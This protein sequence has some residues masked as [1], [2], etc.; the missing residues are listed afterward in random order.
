MGTAY[1]ISPE[2]IDSG[3]TVD[4]RSDLYSLAAI[5]FEML[6][7]Q[8]PYRGSNVMELI[9]KHKSTPIPALQPLRPDLPPIVDQFFQ[10]GLAKYPEQRYQTPQ[11]FIEALQDLRRAA[12][13]H[14]QPTSLSRASS[15]ALALPEQSTVI[16]VPAS[17]EKAPAPRVAARLVHLATGKIFLLSNQEMIIGRRDPLRN[18]YPDISLADKMVGRR[19]ACIRN[20]QGTFTIEDLHSRNRTRLNG[21]FLLPGEERALKH[22]DILRFGNIEMRFELINGQQAPTETKDGEEATS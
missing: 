8:P 19:H 10:K 20:R 12:A 2:Q 17:T 7:G 15:S 22:G 18:L 16:E 1:Y 3:H 9:V 4:I 11:E 5:L 21:R 13:N 6:A 14:L